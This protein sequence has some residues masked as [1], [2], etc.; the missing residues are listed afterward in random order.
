MEKKKAKKSYNNV[1]QKIF[2][3]I[4]LLAILASIVA[5]MMYNF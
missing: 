3:Y 5:S 4:M 1:I 2:V